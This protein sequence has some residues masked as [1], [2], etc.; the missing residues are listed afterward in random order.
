LKAKLF[1]LTKKYLKI[2]Y[3]T[4]R[5]IKQVAIPAVHF[6]LSVTN[7]FFLLRRQKLPLV[8]LPAQEKIDLFHRGFP[9]PS[10]LI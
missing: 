3:F 2:N 4:Q 7:L 1:L 6:K 10:G 8:A 9:F 5:K